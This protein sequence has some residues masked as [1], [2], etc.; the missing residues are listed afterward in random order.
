MKRLVTATF[1]ALV[2][3]GATAVHAAPLDVASRLVNHPAAD[4]WGVYGTGEKHQ[5]VKDANVN[6]GAAFQ[7]TSAGAGANAW[8]IQ[9]GV[10]TSKPVKKGDVVLLAFWA[11]TV[12]PASAP[13]S[14]VVQQSAAPYTKVGSENLTLDA[15]WRL[16]YVS[17]TADHDYPAGAMGASVQLATGAHT[18]ALGPVFVLDFGPG[19]DSKFLPR[20]I[21]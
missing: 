16:Y 20:N 21:P 14:V 10:P 3:A 6:G 18:I 5:I 2:L 7:V 13:V 17:G 4:Q 11:K 8:D 1:A 9:A 12:T 15:N 19:Y